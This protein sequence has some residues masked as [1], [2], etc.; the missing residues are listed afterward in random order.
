MYLVDTSICVSLLRGRTP[1]VL[2]RIRRHAP[3]DVGI[4]SLTV[5]ELEYGV[6][7]AGRPDRERALL[8]GFLLPF[9]I[10]G[11]DLAA[12]IEYGR[13]R[14]ALEARGQRI[15]A[16]DTLLAAQA[17]SLRATMVTHNVREF[18]RVPGLKVEDWAS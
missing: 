17:L 9:T 5:G 1:N 11:F 4:S 15:G 3:S 8:D 7:K 2:T 18:G 13:L 14:Y 12:G 6:A 10:L 16:I